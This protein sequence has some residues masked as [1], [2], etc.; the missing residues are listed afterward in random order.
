MISP[1][2]ISVKIYSQTGELVASYYSNTQNNSDLIVDLFVEKIGNLKSFSFQL[3]NNIID[4][5]FTGM[6]CRFYVDGVHWYSGYAD[7]IPEQDSTGASI[8]ITGLGYVEKLKTKS[9]TKSYT[10]QTLDYIIKDIGSTYLDADLNVLYDVAKIVSPSISNITIEFKDKKLYEVFESLLSIANYDYQNT[11]YRFWVDKDKY[12]TFGAVDSTP[13]QSLFEGFHYQNPEVETVADKIINQ[14]LMFRT[15]QTSEKEVEYI[16]TY[17]DDDSISNFGLKEEKIVFSDYIDTNST[18][19]LANDIIERFKNPL[20][21]L[22]IRD[23]EASSK[24]AL[25]FYTLTNKRSTG[26]KNVNKLES[27]TGWDVSH[28]LNTTASIS[29]D[30]VL[31][32]RTALKLVTASGCA[33][34]YMEYILPTIMYFPTEFRLYVYKKQVASKLTIKLFDTFGN[35][36]SLQVGYNNEPID[37]WIKYTVNIEMSFG[38]GLLEVNKDSSNSGL[39]LVNKDASNQGHIGVRFLL[40]AGIFNLTKIQII[41]DSNNSKTIYID[42]MDTKLNNYTSRKIM[43]EQVKY[44]LGNARTL[45]AVFGDKIESL[46]D[47]I[48]NKSDIGKIAYNV[49]SKQ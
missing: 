12:F 34:D 33:N 6:E 23:M 3:S 14:I 40:Q 24:L 1:K 38:D 17:K 4:P 44:S 29:T 31:T 32:N 19:D 22:K 5:L 2:Q 45:E 18:A 35:T 28:L 41:I 20:T 13:K 47:E 15:K 25:G 8:D 7:I 37:E 27:L 39:L 49:F 11:Q 46:V 9:I 43:L 21:K 42:Q 48:G 10:A 26:F 30:K 36:K 16:A